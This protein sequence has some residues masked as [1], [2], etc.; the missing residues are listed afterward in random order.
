MHSRELCCTCA[1]GEC[2]HDHAVLPKHSLPP[3]HST[4][5]LSLQ[6]GSTTKGLVQFGP[7]VTSVDSGTGQVYYASLRT[8][9]VTTVPGNYDRTLSTLY[10]NRWEHPYL[11]ARLHVLSCTESHRRGLYLADDPFIVL[12]PP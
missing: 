5:S 12:T 7:T 8:S 10:T 3:P 9:G 1:L 2:P 4:L 11:S 6:R